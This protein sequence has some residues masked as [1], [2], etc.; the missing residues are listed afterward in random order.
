ME[1]SRFSMS[2]QDNPAST[3]RFWVPSETKVAFPVLP[4]PR[5]EIRRPIG[6]HLRQAGNAH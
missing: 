5:T 1:A 4:L 2:R 6:A 3:R